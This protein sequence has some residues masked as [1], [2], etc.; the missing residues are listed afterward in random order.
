MSEN[1]MLP[2]NPASELQRSIEGAMAKAFSP[3][4]EVELGFAEVTNPVA[5]LFP[6][7]P[8]ATLGC[9]AIG[10]PHAHKQQP[11]PLPPIGPIL[12][13]CSVQTLINYLPAARVGDIGFSPTCGSMFPM[14]EIFTGSSNVFIGG[15]RAARMLDITMHCWPP[16]DRMAR[17]EVM[18]LVK[19]MK[20]AM[21]VASGAGMAAQAVSVVGEGWAAA[22]ADSSAMQEARALDAGMMAAQMAADVA[23]MVA[24]MMM[25]KDPC[26][27]P[28]VGGIILGHPNVLIGGFPMPSGLQVAGRVLESVKGRRPRTRT[29]ESFEGCTSCPP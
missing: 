28:P 17:A 27:G 6:A 22:D 2:E 23:A 11:F 10:L 24:G 21:I 8:A 26:I 13:G 12:L 4:Q 5:K 29:N 16:K 19:A 20:A 3:V 25:G 9:F 14:F 7:L 18:A 15:M 1:D